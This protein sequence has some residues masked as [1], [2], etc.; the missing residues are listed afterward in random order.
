MVPV[1]GLSA[2]RWSTWSIIAVRESV[3]DAAGAAGDGRGAQHLTDQYIATFHLPDS[4]LKRRAQ[5]ADLARGFVEQDIAL[6]GFVSLSEGRR[7]TARRM[8]HFGIAAYPDLARKNPKIWLL[9]AMLV[10][11]P[12]GTKVAK[13]ARVRAEQKWQ[14]RESK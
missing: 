13:A 2:R 8:V 3:H 6:R 10:L 12:L 5:R 11:G 14:A 4:V 1:E 9:R 7:S